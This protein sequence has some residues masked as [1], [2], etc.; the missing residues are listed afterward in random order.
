MDFS[1][2]LYVFMVISL[3]GGALTGIKKGAMREGVK[4]AY[5]TISKQV[6]KF[7]SLSI[8]LASVAISFT[9]FI[10]HPTS[11]Y[12]I[13]NLRKKYYYRF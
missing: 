10:I 1:S 2:F 7:F 8:I 5:F 9:D 13:P 4:L 6:G 12:I 11:I 3:V